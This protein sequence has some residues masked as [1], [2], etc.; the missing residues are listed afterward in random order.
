MSTATEPVPGTSD[1]WSPEVLDWCALEA[2]AREVF[3][4]YG[5]SELR[6]PVFERTDVFVRSLGDETDVVKKEM[7][8]FE[9][10]GGRSLTLRPEGTAGVMR[11]MAASGLAEGDE[12]RVFYMGPMF[13]G[14]R[15]AAGRRRQFHQ[16][17]GEAVGRCAPAADVEC[18]AMLMH[19]LEAIGVSGGKLL[20]N[21]RGVAE[22]RE[23]VAVALRTH[24]ES[25]VAGMCEDCRRR[26]TANVWRI[27]DCKNPDCQEHILAAP[28]MVDLLGDSSRAFFKAVCQGLE[29]L[30]LAH[31]IAP[32]LVRGLDY[33]VHTVFEVTH[34][35]LGAQDAIAGGG[36]YAITVPGSS[37]PIAG[38]GFAAGMERLL[39]ARES[40]GIKTGAVAATDVY[41]AS[42][43]EAMVN[44]GV[45][46]AST[47][48]RQ[49]IRVMAETTGRSI[50]AQMRTAN[51][52]G[53]GIVLL[54][55]EQ[56]KAKGVV[57]GKTMATGEQQEVPL[58]ELASWVKARLPQG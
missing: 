12:R 46:L 8:T 43:G 29:K 4:L 21:T 3:S 20:L 30:G 33:Y 38:V 42:L 58:T 31:E 41:V 22:D 5:Y 17:G 34:H 52:L 27:L 51:K 1:I 23:G 36:R 26:F 10:R 45:L 14:E 19:Y 49:G 50:K 9:D 37:H 18:I 39:M 55:G 32:R 25:H 48:R 2:K 6:T 54:L 56:E 16:V 35:G 7:Y 11:A 57:T 13:R 28:H 44:D 40:L 53:A 47:L 24:F 15:P